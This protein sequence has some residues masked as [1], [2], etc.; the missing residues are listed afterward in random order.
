MKK[1]T[2]VA[3][4]KV[5]GFKEDPLPLE[6]LVRDIHAGIYKRLPGQ[7]RLEDVEAEAAANLLAESATGPA[8]KP[9]KGYRFK[10]ILKETVK[11]VLGR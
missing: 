10:S 11:S 3:L 5:E 7:L 6:A 1:E 8:Q 4:S 9:W 2:V